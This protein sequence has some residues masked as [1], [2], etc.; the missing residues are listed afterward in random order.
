[1][2]LP[3]AA[4]KVFQGKIFSVHQWEQKLYD[5]TTATFEMLK[6]PGTIQIIPTTDDIIYISYEEQ[7]TKP[8]TYTLLGGRMEPHEDPL[9]TAKRELL[10]ESGLISNDWEILKT[11]EYEGKIEWPMYVYVARN[12][13]K[14]AEQQL[15]PG[16]Q[17]EV[18]KVSFDE[19]IKIASSEKFWNQFFTSDILRMRLDKEKLEK[20]KQKLF[21]KN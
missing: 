7:P 5:G 17:I 20:F 16:E 10:E 13:K 14:I 1:M 21:K 6:R 2:K 12:C 19:F 18:K 8:R 11:Y 4:K 9:V 15:D 3:Q